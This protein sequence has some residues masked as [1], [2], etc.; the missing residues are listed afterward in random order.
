MSSTASRSPIR[1]GGWSRRRRRH[2]A[3]GGGPEPADPPG[4]RCPPR[5]WGVARAP[6][7]VAGRADVPL[8]PRGGHAGVRTGAGRAAPRSTRSWSA[9]PPI[10]SSPA[11]TLVDP[12]GLAADA[13]DG[14]RLVPPVGRRR[15]G[16]LRHVRRGRRAQRAAGARR[17]DR[18]APGR[19][20]PRDQGRDRRLA[21]RRLGL[22]LH[23]LSRRRRVRPDGLR[24]PARHA[25]AR[26][27]ARLGRPAHAGGLD[28]RVG[29]EG[30]PL[31]RWSTPRSAGAAPTCTCSTGRPTSGG[32]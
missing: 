19:R 12:A 1:T 10:R 7:R 8:V 18:R 28:R 11:R 29:V 23:P 32:R 2:P 27:P 4:A 15:A 25:M 20:D 5:S 30:R 16:R 6:C 13:T 31:G 9:R 26:G 3:L 24:A 21:P 17:R 14:D 22:P